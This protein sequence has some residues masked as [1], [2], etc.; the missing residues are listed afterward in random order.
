KRPSERRSRLATDLAVVM[1]SRSM[2][3]QMPVPTRSRFVAAAAAMRATN[4]S[5]VC[6]YCSGSSPP[7]NGL[8]RLVGVCVCSGTQRDSKLRASASRASSSM[9]MAYSV[10]KMQTPIFMRSSCS[11]GRGDARRGR[12]REVGVRRKPAA[13][14]ALERERAAAGAREGAAVGE[15]A[16]RVP[17]GGNPA[18]V[19][20]DGAA[21]VVDIDGEVLDDGP[22]AAPLLFLDDVQAFD[23]G[24]DRAEGHDVGRAEL[25][26]GGEIHGAHARLQGAQPVAERR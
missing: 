1:V 24:C 13:M 12:Q 7:A 21:R 3:R 2:I 14:A 26:A 23:E 20:D 16:A 9:R 15:R 22:D 17:G 25:A 10:A 18:A 11:A 19:A 6:L 8:R 4:G 5:S